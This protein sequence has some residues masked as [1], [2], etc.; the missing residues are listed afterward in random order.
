LLDIARFINLYNLPT[1]ELFD[2][3]TPITAAMLKEC[4]KEQEIRFEPGD[5]LLIRTG[6]TEAWCALTEE[7]RGAMPLRKHRACTGVAQ[8]EEMMRWHWE[9]GIV[10]VA[11]D[12]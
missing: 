12:V 5:I 8:G 11:S 9:N 3:T 10:A 7:Q 6:W 1:L 4:A 2:N